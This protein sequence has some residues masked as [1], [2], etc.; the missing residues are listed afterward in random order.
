[1][2]QNSCFVYVVISACCQNKPKFSQKCHN[3]NCSPASK[4]AIYTTGKKT[5]ATLK[6]IFKLTKLFCHIWVLSNLDPRTS[7]NPTFECKH[8]NLVKKCKNCFVSL[9]PES[10]P[11]RLKRP[12][13]PSCLNSRA[14]NELK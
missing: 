4:N 6:I 3:I 5:F 13:T 12:K 14:L 10:R 7:Y 8:C 9:E 11:K 1:M 2:N